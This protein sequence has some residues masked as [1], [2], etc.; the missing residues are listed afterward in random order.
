MLLR[1]LLGNPSPPKRR[2]AWEAWGKDNFKSFKADFEVKFEAVNGV[3]KNHVKECNEFKRQEFEKL[4][5]DDKKK[6]SDI[7]HQEWEEAKRLLKDQDSAPRLLE[8][9]DAQK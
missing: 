8:P 9:A 7:V 3:E 1:R 2:A 5:E 6:W 4:S